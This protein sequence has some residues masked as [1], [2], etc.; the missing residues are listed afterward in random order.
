[1][2][3]VTVDWL[4][5]MVAEA[6]NARGLSTTRET[7]AVYIQ[8]WLDEEIDNR[9]ASMCKT[10]GHHVTG[11]LFDPYCALCGVNL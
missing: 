5:G 6:L 7:E 2:N 8:R 11:G 4:A 3:E 9:V 10:N 1:M